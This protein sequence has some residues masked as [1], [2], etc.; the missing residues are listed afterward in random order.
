MTVPHDSRQDELASIDAL[1][2]ANLPPQ[3]H[4]LRV[5]YWIPHHYVTGGIKILLEHMRHLRARGHYI[6][7]VSRGAPGGR[8]VPDWSNIQVDE[9]ICIGRQDCCWFGR[10]RTDILVVGY[11]RDLIELDGCPV[12]VLYVEQG[13]ELLFGDL[14]TYIDGRQAEEVYRRAMAMPVAIVGVSPFICELLHKQFGRKSG[15]VCNAVDT[16]AFHPGELAL[17]HRALLVGNPKTRFKDFSTALQVLDRVFKQIPDLEVTWVCQQQPTFHGIRF[18]LRFVVDPKQTDL[19]GI[20]RQHDLLLF[21]SLYEAFG[22]PPLEAMASGVPVVATDCGGILSYARTGENCLLAAPRYIDGLTEAVLT[23]FRDPEIARLL[24]EKGRQ[25]ALN[26]SW[27][28]AVDRLE[29]ALY[30]V[31]ALEKSG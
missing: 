27:E 5:C 14:S 12:P 28:H 30:R 8:A 7:A 22:L 13:H 6:Q 16:E 31:A 2:E 18:P 19:P 1:W 9:E 10:D 21:T 26:F 3:T 25:T 4:K 29:D 20:Y 23:V 11:F 24:S 17:R 15:L